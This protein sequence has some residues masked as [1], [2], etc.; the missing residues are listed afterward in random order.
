MFERGLHKL[1]RHTEILIWTLSDVERVSHNVIHGDMKV[2]LI[3]SN[4]MLTLSLL[5]VTAN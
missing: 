4:I 1:G 3:A 5:K 2:N